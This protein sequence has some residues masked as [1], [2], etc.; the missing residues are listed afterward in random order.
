MSLH[1][2]IDIQQRETALKQA[3]SPKLAA[4]GFLVIPALVF[5]VITATASG[6]RNALQDI[7]P[8]ILISAGGLYLAYLHFKNRRRIEVLELELLKLKRRLAESKD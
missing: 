5:T 4:A 1:D 2:S 7:Y 6:G 3:S 8:L